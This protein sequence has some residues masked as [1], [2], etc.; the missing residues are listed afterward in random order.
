MEMRK[1]RNGEMGNSR[2]LIN[3]VILGRRNGHQVHLLEDNELG[4]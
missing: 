2:M 3:P 4:E 1:W